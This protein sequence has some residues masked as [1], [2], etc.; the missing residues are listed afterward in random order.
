MMKRLKITTLAIIALLICGTLVTFAS[1]TDPNGNDAG[2]GRDAGDNAAGAIFITPGNYTGILSY[3]T[4]DDTQDWYNFTAYNTHR[5]YVDMTP[6]T[7]SDFQL[8]VQ[9]P[10]G[11]IYGSYNP[12]DA[13]ESV[14]I[15]ATCDGTWSIRISRYTGQGQYKFYLATV[16]Y[17]PAVPPAP[18]GPTSGYVYTSYTYTTSTTDPEGD[19]ICYEFD[20]NDGAT[21]QV[22]WYASGAT[23]SASHQ[24]KYPTTY[25]LKVRAK[26]I[27]GFW[28]GWST[29]RSVT[30]SQNDAGSGGD[31][32]N[33]AATAI[34]ITPGTYKGTLYYPNPVDTI[35]F[36]SFTAQLGDLIHATMTPP[37]DADFHLELLDPNGEIRSGSYNGQGQTEVVDTTAA[38]GGTWYLRIFRYTGE[39]QYTFTL[40]V[41]PNHAVLT[42]SVPQ[43]GAD[44]AI[45]WIDGVAYTAYANTP[46]SVTL[47][48]GS[49]TIQAERSFL[50]EEWMPGYY[51]IYTFWKWSDGVTANP[52]T[53][54]LT[55]DLSLSAWYLRSKYAIV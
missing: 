7:G 20:W 41:T 43:A 36:Y 47:A 11:T 40:A 22:G 9:S 21:T 29:F 5:I 25:Q 1:A 34:F 38:L 13:M 6:P 37:S 53:I 10:T 46:V 54:N 51:F 31:A 55:G 19:T 32:G 33:T 23:A 27:H 42:I 30:L 24:W 28:S 49:H 45:I 15:T 17:P 4:P 12:G 48:K 39:G 44:G 3:P 2:S 18:S 8:E 14:N 26:D 50:K 35:D 52:R 16:N